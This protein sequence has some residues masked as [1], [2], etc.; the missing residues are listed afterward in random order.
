[1]DTE[2]ASS[3][4]SKCCGHTWLCLMSPKQILTTVMV[5]MVIE[6]NTDNAKT[7]FH[8]FSTTIPISKKLFF[9]EH[10]L[11]NALRDTLM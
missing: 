2:Y 7:T 8:L 6:K 1:M 9:P 4:W 10:E 5:H 3:Q 11:K